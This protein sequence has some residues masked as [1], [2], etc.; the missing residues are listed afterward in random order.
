M[1][2]IQALL[3]L[4]VW[5]ITI[6]DNLGVVEKI[7]IKTTRIRALGGEQM[8]FSNTDLTD[9]RIHNFKKMQKRRVV[10]KLSIIYQTP[11]EKLR[12]ITGIV[13]KII[14]NQEEVVFDRGHF[15]SYGDFSLNFEFV[16]YL[17]GGD[18]NKYMDTQESINVA[19]F[20]AFEKKEI[21]FAYPTQTVYMEQNH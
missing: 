10:F 1:K 4:I 2:G 6:E 11:A 21:A 15:A 3:N 13:R 7:G 19:I 8:V 18:Y 17:R 16:Y 14:Q 5:V 12:K 20:E 9:S